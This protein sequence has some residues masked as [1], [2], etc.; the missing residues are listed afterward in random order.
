MDLTKK[1]VKHK[2]LQRNGD[3]LCILVPRA[4]IDES[5]WSQ[6]TRLVLEFLPHR[7]MIIIT[8]EKNG[9]TQPIE[10]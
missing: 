3:N 1:V 8:D 9:D 5:D 10:H 7:K 6:E 4:W 2:K